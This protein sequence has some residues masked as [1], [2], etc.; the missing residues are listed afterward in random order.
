M[1]SICHVTLYTI[2]NIK[3]LIAFNRTI[4]KGA[5]RLTPKFLIQSPHLFINPHIILTLTTITLTTFYS[6][7]KE[8]ISDPP[9]Y[10]NA[11]LTVG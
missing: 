8:D 4:G 9:I 6:T 11:N 5:K 10:L 3:K 7:L 2:V 1:Y